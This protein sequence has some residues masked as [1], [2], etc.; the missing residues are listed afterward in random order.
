MI[1]SVIR[2]FLSVLRRYKMAMFL[3]IAGLSMAFAAFIIILMQ[4]NYEYT[5]DRCHST[6]ERVF[7]AELN[8]TGGFSLI[9]PRG[10]VESVISSSPHIEAGTLINP[11][12]SPIYFTFTENDEKKG[13]REAIQTCHPNITR[14]F[15]FHLVAGDPECLND[16]EKAIIPESMA[17]K[18]FGS[19]LAVGKVLHAEESIWSKEKENLTIGAVYRDFP[20]N[21]QL[22]NLIYTAIDENY[23]RT[24]FQAS[25][26]ICYLLLDDKAN[27]EEV[28]GNFNRTF[29]FEKI[30]DLELQILLRPLQD[31]YYLNEGADGRIVRG[32]S[33]ETTRLL[34]FIAILI[35]LV[36]LINYTNFSTALTP[37]RIKSINTQKV[38]GSSDKVLRHSLLLEA[39][40]LAMV[41]WGISLFIIW[42]I[43]RTTTLPFVNADMRLNAN[44]P[45]LLLS[46]VVAVVTGVIAGL[47]PSRYIVSFPPA[48]V[49]KG[50]FGLSPTGRRMRTA[51]ICIQFVVSITLIVSAGIVQLQNN[52]MRNYSLGFDKD[53][54]AVVGLN[55][56]L[57]NQHREAYVN[58]LKQF[59][60][61]E[62][63]A[64]SMEKAGSQDG[65]GTYS[66]EYN[67]ESFSYYMFPVSPNFLRVMG[68]PVT[69]GRDFSPAD[70]QSEEF[71]MIFNKEAHESLRMETGATFSK[72]FKGRAIGFT[73]EVKFT[74]LRQGDGNI[75]FVSGNIPMQLTISYIRLQAGTD[76]HAAV[77]HIQKTMKEI[78]PAFPFNIEFYDTIFDHLYQKE[79]NLR[80]LITLFSLLAILLSLVGVFGLV[81]FETQYRRK[82]IAIRKVHGSTIAQ[83]L[84]MINKQYIYIILAC[85][86]I[87][88]PIAWFAIS[89]WLEGFAYKTPVHWWVYAIALFIVL[90]I[91]LAT[92]TF[93]SWRAARSN[94][95]DCLKSE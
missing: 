37:V 50:S 82:E 68:I 40:I 61:I 63:V 8:R 31:I 86:L 78:D 35:M 2:N 12:I 5:F 60:G 76:V 36:A 75:A 19:E 84:E 7:R 29:D 59:P 95:V 81:V 92:V 24:N 56:Q 72:W 65:Y 85:F 74:S 18:M 49:L 41:S 1:K 83:I 51:L 3:N 25:N 69:E 26:F 14:V 43:N 34:F 38:L 70:E 9:L 13:F 46:G 79:V 67:G 4:V 10:F 28:A 54:I 87:A 42:I 77:S 91:T 27:A 71:A 16:P 80:S 33:I 17:R 58:K 44:M 66:E 93:Q 89:K 64:F 32:G 53:Q 47:Y 52:Y 21:T 57:Y 73:D 22:K 94:P 23:M 55:G 6:S 48:L 62:D 15:D 30:D 11:F 90:G 45:I 88:S 39:A 20:E